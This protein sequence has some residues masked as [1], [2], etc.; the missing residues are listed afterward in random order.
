MYFE[1]QLIFIRIEERKTGEIKNE[2]ERNE[3]L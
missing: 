2:Y 3:K 1:I